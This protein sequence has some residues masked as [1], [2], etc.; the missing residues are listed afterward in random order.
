MNNASAVNQ[1]Y[2]LLVVCTRFS[3]IEYKF[4]N[5]TYFWKILQYTKLS[6]VYFCSVLLETNLMNASA[7]NQETKR[8]HELIGVEDI[9]DAYV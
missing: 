7:V 4:L 8:T 2:F 3:Y 6:Y 1:L 5:R 9:V